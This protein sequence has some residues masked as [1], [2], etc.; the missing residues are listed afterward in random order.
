[1]KALDEHQLAQN[2]LLIFTSDNGPASNSRQPLAD[3]GHDG[4]GG[5]RGTK[6]PS[7]KA[8]IACHSSP[9][10]PATHPQAA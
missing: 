3:A 7:M 1:M 9:A 4:S 8:V 10:G 6:A 2:T 5:L